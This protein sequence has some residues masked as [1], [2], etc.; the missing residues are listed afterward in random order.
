MRIFK[1]RVIPLVESLF[2]DEDSSESSSS[3]SEQSS[4]EERNGWQKPLTQQVFPDQQN[5]HRRR[6]ESKKRGSQQEEKSLGSPLIDYRR[7]GVSETTI[8]EPWPGASGTK[9]YSS[10][11]RQRSPVMGRSMMKPLMMKRVFTEEL[12]QCSWS[13]KQFQWSSHNGTPEHIEAAQSLL[14]PD[15]YGMMQTPLDVPLMQFGRQVRRPRRWY[16]CCSG[17]HAAIVRGCRE[18]GWPRVGY[19]LPD[20][21]FLPGLSTLPPDNIW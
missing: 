8:H 17:E 3:E 10:V 2:A 16:H 12:R 13:A 4:S 14:H 21:P 18:K 11:W 20:H 19:M 15:E 1:E 9:N 5:I 7:A 6:L